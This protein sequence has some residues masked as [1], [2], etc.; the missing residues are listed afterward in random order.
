MKI[1]I[2]SDHRGYENKNKIIEKLKGKY[3]I[4]DYGP[5]EANPEDDYP[6]YALKVGEAVRDKK[7]ELGIVLCGSGIGVSIAANKVKNIRAAKVD[8]I[9][10]AE[11]SRKHNDANIIAL[12]ASKSIAELIELIEKFINTEFSNLERHKRRISIIS[13]Y[14][15]NI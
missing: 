13:T 9:L 11:L 15:D 5:V 2:G 1:G 6:E 4:I 7:V 3:Q 10:D 8:N 14:E 12:N